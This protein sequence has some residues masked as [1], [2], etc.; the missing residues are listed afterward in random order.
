[1]FLLTLFIDSRV[2]AGDSPDG[3]ELANTRDLLQLV[4]SEILEDEPIE[5]ALLRLLPTT[6]SRPNY[7]QLSIAF[8]I[9]TPFLGVQRRTR[10]LPSPLELLLERISR[11]QV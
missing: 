9:L 8:K 10:V 3:W 1:M 6:L 5:V 7:F 11:N 4:M 2:T